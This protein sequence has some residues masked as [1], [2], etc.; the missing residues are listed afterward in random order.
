LLCGICKGLIRSQ[1]KKIKKM[2]VKTFIYSDVRTA[3]PEKIKHD[4][5]FSKKSKNKII[6][7]YVD[8]RKIQR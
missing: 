1:Y 8:L 6:Y 2:K 4:D 5:E 3:T 7:Y